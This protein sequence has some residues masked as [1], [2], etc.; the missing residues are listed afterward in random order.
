MITAFS[1]QQLK[2]LWTECSKNYLYRIF[3][4]LT[5]FCSNCWYAQVR[6]TLLS[7]KQTLY[8]IVNCNICYF[9]C[10]HK[11]SEH[12][13]LYVHLNFHLVVLDWILIAL[14]EISPLEENLNPL[15]NWSHPI[16]KRIKSSGTFSKCWCK[17]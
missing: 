11:L 5:D 15:S 1:V 9:E 13:R 6:Y 7:S 8:C 12:T 3:V 4:L 16:I 14:I 2:N 17:Y 10:A